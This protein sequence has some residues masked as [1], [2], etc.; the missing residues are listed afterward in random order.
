VATPLAWQHL[1]L[2]PPRQD[3]SAYADQVL[4]DAD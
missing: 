3:G 2:T 4:F 1:G